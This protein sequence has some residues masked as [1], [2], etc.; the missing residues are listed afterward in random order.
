MPKADGLPA[1]CLT[2]TEVPYLY[3]YG[4]SVAGFSRNIDSNYRAFS[5]I[6]NISQRI[7]I[8]IFFNNVCVSG[9]LIQNCSKG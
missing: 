5:R 9:I 6:D 3:R 2:A 8:N 1:L 7:V 4:E